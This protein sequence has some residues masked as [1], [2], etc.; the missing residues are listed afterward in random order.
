[1]GPLINLKCAAAM[2]A[3]PHFRVRGY[4]IWLIPAP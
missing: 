3:L 4:P 2:V 1:M